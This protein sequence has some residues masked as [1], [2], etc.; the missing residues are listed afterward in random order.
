VAQVGAPG[1]FGTSTFSQIFDIAAGITSLSISF[2][3]MWGVE[4]QS[5]TDTFTAI[6]SYESTF[7]VV[8]QELL[9]ETSDTGLFGSVTYFSGLVELSNLSNV[10]SN[11]FISF[12][13]L[14]TNLGTGTRVALDNVSVQSV[15]EPSI[16]VLFGLGLLGMGLT[17]RLNVKN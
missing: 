16:I 10:P 1:T 2:D 17:R 4:K 9:V 15:S 14:E 8:E 11:G 6:F 5:N 7:G 3:Y 12:S 13:L